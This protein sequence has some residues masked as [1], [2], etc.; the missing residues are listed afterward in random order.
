MAS[1]FLQDQGR[2]WNGTAENRVVPDAS[3]AMKQ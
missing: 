3:S 2:G 1:T